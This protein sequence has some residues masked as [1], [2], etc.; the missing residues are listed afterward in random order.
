M[1]VAALGCGADDEPVEPVA[2]A[3]EY[4]AL[5]PAAPTL[6]RLTQAQY[7]NV[8]TDLLGDGLALPATLEPDTRAEGLLAVG[9]SVTPISS[10]GVELYTEGALSLATQVMA[11]AEGRAKVV[12]CQP[13][14]ATDEACMRQLLETF[15]RRAWRRPLTED[16]I[17]SFLA[18]GKSAADTLGTF[19]GGATYVVAALLQ[20]PH[21]LYRVELG[22]QLT[23]WEVASRLSFF[24]WNTAPDEALLDAAADGTLDTAEG[25]AA[26]AQRLLDDARS[27][28][29]VRSFI[30]DWLHLHEL[31]HLNKDPNIYKHFTPEL[32][33]MA[34]E[35]TLL[36]AEHLVFDVEADFRDLFT[37]QTTFVNRR[38]AAIYNIAAVTDEGF[39][40]VQLPQG[41]QR[42]GFLG[43]V[44]FLGLHS[45]AVESSATLRGAFLREHVLCDP[46]PPPPAGLN[47]AIPEPS[48][49]ARTL[50]ER[51][52]EHMQDPSCSVCHEFIDVPGFGFENFDG[53]G[54]FRLTDHGAPI[55]PTGRLDNIDFADF[56]ELAGLISQSPQ[57]T[58][59]VVKKLYSY[60][61][62]HPV[63][64][65]EAGVLAELGDRFAAGEYRL[66]QLMLDIAT[67]RAFVTQG[68]V[69]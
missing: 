61:V 43:Q 38:L 40:Q 54:R 35:E 27:R 56:G 9:A 15:G 7:A 1:L 41:E 6:I 36:L 24:L 31:D 2:P 33:A 49:T 65:G 21:F 20:S 48:E 47:T 23:G 14:G 66:K 37:T 4:E 45:H 55:D 64:K 30:T 12:P 68:E 29:A 3:V 69:Q 44:A 25:I 18:I 46:V 53:I 52:L 8:V 11:T 50:K 22:L 39:G 63:E 5:E 34:R 16:E 28:Q 51:L 58:A 57:L 17:A 10:R 60:A 19:D 13:S 42:R 67:H 62:A 26:Q 59:C 32:G